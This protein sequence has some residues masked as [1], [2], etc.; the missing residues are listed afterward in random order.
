[1]KQKN[2][3]RKYSGTVN[4]DVSF[5]GVV[6]HS[7]QEAEN[8]IRAAAIPR[9]IDADV[10]PKASNIE[11]GEEVKVRI[12]TDKEKKRIEKAV[13]KALKS[14]LSDPNLNRLDDEAQDAI[15][16]FPF[17][18]DLDEDE[19]EEFALSVYAVKD[20]V[21]T[22]VVNQLKKLVRKIK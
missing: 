13:L 21:C 15:G 7:P 9:G 8:K 14:H 11:E 12:L 5:N 3:L 18:L 4:M 6:A 17:M 19:E 2:V 22:S 16:D 10:T 20:K 1:M